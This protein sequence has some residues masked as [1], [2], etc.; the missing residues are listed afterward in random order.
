MSNSYILSADLGQSADYT[1]LA[2][3]QLPGNGQM[4]LIDL[5][6]LPLGMP[7]PEQVQTIK[8]RHDALVR[9]ARQEYTDSYTGDDE[10]RPG[11]VILVLDGTGVGAAIVD[12]V[13]ASAMEPYV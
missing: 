4:N 13:R 7:Y 8:K 6:K 1:A 3:L 2:T 10:E 9:L 11:E 5:V 12:M